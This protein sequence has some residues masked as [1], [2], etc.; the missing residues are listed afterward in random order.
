MNFNSVWSRVTG[1][2]AACA[3]PASL[4]ERFSANEVYDAAYYSAL[5]S[6]TR[7]F[8][9]RKLF[10]ALSAD[11]NSHVRRLR[12][13]Y[14]LLTGQSLAPAAPGVS[15]PPSLLDAVR[16]RHGEELSAAAEYDRAAD[17]W[18]DRDA[19]RLFAELAADERR[20]AAELKRLLE[21][22]F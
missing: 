12:P 9:A 13:A 4:L 14:F 18:P 1:A 19:A 5:A 11:E 22:C 17:T 7:S 21:K 2:S 15:L 16:I 10:C 8:T 20:H 6:K 3:E